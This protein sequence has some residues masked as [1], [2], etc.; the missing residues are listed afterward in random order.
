MFRQEPQQSAQCQ[1]P[2]AYAGRRSETR[3]QQ[4]FDPH[5]SL[6]LPARGAQRAANADF[7]ECVAAYAPG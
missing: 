4:V 3:Q 1:E 5:L 6:N 2:D 7:T